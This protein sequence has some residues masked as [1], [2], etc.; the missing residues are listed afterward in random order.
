MNLVTSERAMRHSQVLQRAEPRSIINLFK[1]AAYTNACI[2][3]DHEP[4]SQAKRR[5]RISQRWMKLTVL[6]GA[7]APPPNNV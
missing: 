1:F 2:P 4:K 7:N 6:P 5:A 3:T